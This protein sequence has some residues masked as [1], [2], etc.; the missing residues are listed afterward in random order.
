MLD[1]MTVGIVY[2]GHSDTGTDLFWVQCNWDICCGKYDT[3][4]DICW[5][6]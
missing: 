4:T 2:F 6:G 3:G 1:R 5:T